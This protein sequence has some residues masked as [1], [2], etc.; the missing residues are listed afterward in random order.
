MI[1]VPS[2]SALSTPMKPPLCWTTPNTVESPRPVPLP[3]SLVVKKGSKIL[4]RVAASMP[5]P[6]SV[7]ESQT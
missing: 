3:G 2:P 1:A 4:D 5:T 6:V 7:T